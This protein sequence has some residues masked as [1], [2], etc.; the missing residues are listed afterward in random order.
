[1]SRVN[2]IYKLSYNWGGTALILRQWGW[3][4]ATNP[5]MDTLWMMVRYRADSVT[6]G[7]MFAEELIH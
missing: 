1:M 5:T 4:V 7:C 2:G 3:H 6:H